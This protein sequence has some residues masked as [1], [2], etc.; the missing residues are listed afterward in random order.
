MNCY[1][2]DCLSI[3]TACLNVSSSCCNVSFR[4]KST[5]WGAFLAVPFLDTRVFSNSTLF[6]F[7]SHHTSENYLVYHGTKLAHS[8]KGEKE[9]TPFVLLF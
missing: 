7:F 8:Q 6:L 4:M 3:K 1:Y 2:S 5:S 9:S